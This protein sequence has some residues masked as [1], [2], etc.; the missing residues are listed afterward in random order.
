MPCHAII[1]LFIVLIIDAGFE[2]SLFIAI[3][4]IFRPFSPQP[5]SD[6]RIDAIIYFSAFIDY[7][8]FS[9]FSAIFFT[10]TL[11]LRADIFR[12]FH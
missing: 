5:L 1:A 3:T 11:L 4:P 2:L 9:L 12:C 6:F 7:F 10:L 8:S